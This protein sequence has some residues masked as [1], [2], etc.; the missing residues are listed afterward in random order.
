MEIDNDVL[1][2]G[3]TLQSVMRKHL[4]DDFDEVA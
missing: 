3:R 4:A 1:N 2:V